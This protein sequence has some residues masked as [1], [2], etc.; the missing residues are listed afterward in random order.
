MEVCSGQAGLPSTHWKAS[1]SCLNFTDPTN[2]SGMAWTIGA[3]LNICL[4]MSLLRY[5]QH[6]VNYTYLNI[7]VSVFFTHVNSCNHDLDQDRVFPQYRKAPLCPVRV[8]GPFQSQPVLSSFTFDYFCQI[9]NFIK[10]DIYFPIDPLY[11]FQ[12]IL[13]CLL[14]ILSIMVVIVAHLAVC[15]I[16]SFYFIAAQYSIV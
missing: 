8:N 13:S 7:Q 14:L 6:I 12:Y 1:T 15:C 11:T 10:V 2:R 16:T 4:K 9:L 3:I 5:N